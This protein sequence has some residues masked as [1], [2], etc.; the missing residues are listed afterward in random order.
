MGA[1][2]LLLK[3]KLQHRFDVPFRIQTKPYYD[4]L[5]TGVPA[6]DRLIAGG[7][8]RGALTEI[9]GAESCG[10]TALTFA[11]LGQATQRG[12]CCAGIDAT[13]AFDPSSA[14]E[15]GVNLDRVIWVNCGGN[16]QHALKATDLLI[17]AG[18]F[19]LVVV[20]LADTPI[21]PALGVS[22][23]VLF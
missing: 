18:R 15:A 22:L 6:I 9:C 8:P 16:A 7:I 20:D 21:A 12:G 19:R 23:A 1:A 13:G 2:V 3:S 11:L 14:V 10:R 4:L 5:S 17:Q